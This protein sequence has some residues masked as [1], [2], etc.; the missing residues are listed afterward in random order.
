MPLI[1]LRT[2]DPFFAPPTV[3]SKYEKGSAAKLNAAKSEA[4]WLGR[5]RTNGAS[6]FGLKWVNKF[7]ILEVFFSNGLVDVKCDNWKAILDKLKQVLG[8]YM[9]AARSFFC[10]ARDNH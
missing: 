2:K 6:P 9:V 8:L 7:R 10:R 4:M 1:S 5:W 3:V